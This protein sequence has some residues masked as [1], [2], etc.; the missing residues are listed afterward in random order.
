MLS[1]IAAYRK[2]VDEPFMSFA[3]FENIP[4]LL[5]IA[6]QSDLIRNVVRMLFALRCRMYISHCGTKQLMLMYVGC[7]IMLLCQCWLY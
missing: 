5:N 1:Y 2:V 6:R 4:G 3:D 7:F